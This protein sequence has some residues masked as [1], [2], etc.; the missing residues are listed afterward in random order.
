MYL[1]CLIT[2]QEYIYIFSHLSSSV[3][4]VI[5]QICHENAIGRLPRV[6]RTWSCR[7]RLPRNFFMTT[8][9]LREIIWFKTSRTIIKLLYG[10]ALATI[11]D[12]LEPHLKAVKKTAGRF[13]RLGLHHVAVGGDIIESAD[14]ID[15]VLR[16]L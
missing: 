13:H 16:C 1:M 4:I 9:Y 5:L 8:Q 12:L 10:N 14:S 3:L 15:S 6:Q 11:S 7:S 2:F